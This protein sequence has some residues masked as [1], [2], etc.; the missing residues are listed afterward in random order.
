MR[1]GFG[2]RAFSNIYVKDR[3]I[4]SP[5]ETVVSI[6]L[7]CK[8]AGIS[9]SE[10]EFEQAVLQMKPEYNNID[11]FKN[12][13]LATFERQS[14]AY[15]SVAPSESIRDE[16]PFQLMSRILSETKEHFENKN[17]S[18]DSI[19]NAIIA[20][21]MCLCLFSLS[22]SMTANIHDQSREISIMCSFGCTKAM[23]MKVFICESLVLVISS[24]IAAFFIG[25]FIGNLMT[26]QLAMLQS[27]PFVLQIPWKQLVFLLCLSFVSAV[28]ITFVSARNVLKKSIPDI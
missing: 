5:H 28:V 6:P 12:E 4:D 10:V 18:L 26:L 7:Y 8:L 13:I 23:I 14:D 20:I 17:R 21:S 3:M 15:E 27:C 9:V 19:F 11:F 2:L 16:Y 22:S 24:S 1:T 25:V